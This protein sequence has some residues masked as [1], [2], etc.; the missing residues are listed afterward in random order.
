M[1]V[2]RLVDQIATELDKGN[3]T[4]GVFSDLSKAFDT[5]DHN[6]LLDKLYMYGIRGNCLD[7]IRSYLTHRKQY[8]YLNDVA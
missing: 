5:I 7:W 8:V 6:I 4:I 2:L 1:A 3:I